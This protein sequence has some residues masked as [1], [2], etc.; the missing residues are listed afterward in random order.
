MVALPRLAASAVVEGLAGSRWERT[1]TAVG[2]L[3]RRTHPERARTTVDVLAETRDEV[4]R[5]RRDGDREAEDELVGEWQG[6]LRRL[7]VANPGLVGELRAIVDEFGPDPAG[8]A[9]RGTTV[10]QTATASGNASV[11]QVGGNMYGAGS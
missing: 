3:W 2:E 11:T 5:A 10:T 6:R 7:L 8:R 1:R 9:E 4:L